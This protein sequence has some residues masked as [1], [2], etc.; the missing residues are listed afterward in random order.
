MGNSFYPQISIAHGNNATNAISYQPLPIT[1]MT[2][3]VVLY[4]LQL[5]IGI[6]SGSGVDNLAILV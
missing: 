6:F 4:L 2:T 1:S 5:L 3:D